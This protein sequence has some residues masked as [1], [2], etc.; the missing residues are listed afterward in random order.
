MTNYLS[1]KVREGRRARPRYDVLSRAVAPTWPTAFSLNF[2][3]LGVC[4]KNRIYN[5]TAAAEA[6]SWH[7]SFR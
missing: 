3:P 6:R 4:L 2:S 1:E 5:S 7:D